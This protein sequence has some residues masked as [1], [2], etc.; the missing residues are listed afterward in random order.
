MNQA[1]ESLKGQ[2]STDVDKERIPSAK[3]GLILEKP[4][5]KDQINLQPQSCSMKSERQSIEGKSGPGIKTMKQPEQQRLMPQ[6]R[7]ID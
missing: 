3:Q 7:E 2:I 1:K 4:S 6:P 5:Q